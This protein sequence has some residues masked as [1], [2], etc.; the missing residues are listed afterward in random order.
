MKTWNRLLSLVIPST[1]DY[2]PGLTLFRVLYGC[3]GIVYPPRNPVSRSALVPAPRALAVERLGTAPL[4][5]RALHRDCHRRWRKMERRSPFFRRE[6]DSRQRDERRLRRENPLPDSRVLV[7]VDARVEP[8]RLTGRFGVGCSAMEL[9]FHSDS[10]ARDC[11]KRS[12]HSGSRVM[13][14]R[15]SSSYSGFA[16]RGRPP[17]S[18]GRDFSRRK[19]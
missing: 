13:R 2:R 1:A 12:I 4:L 14:S 6:V 15:S 3:L 10:S 5:A 16:C 19:P 9:H 7:D 17:C 11:A 8:Q 18:P